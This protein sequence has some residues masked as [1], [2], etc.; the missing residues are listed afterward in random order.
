MNGKLYRKD[1][2][3]AVAILDNV[4]LVVM[5]DNHENFPERIFYRT[6]R[7]SEGKKMVEL[8]RDEPM[9]LELEDGRSCHIVI[10]DSSLSADGQFVGVLRVLDILVKPANSAELEQEEAQE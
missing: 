7:L 10:Q 1:K 5:N 6:K 8:F 4:Q 3:D 9:R 2:K